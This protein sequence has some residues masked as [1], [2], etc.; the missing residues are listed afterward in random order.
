MGASE[1]M[2]VI[3]QPGHFRTL[4]TGGTENRRRVDAVLVR[5]G[6]TYPVT[7]GL[8]LLLLFEQAR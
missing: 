1:Q 7:G 6:A 2:N 4:R 8:W 5:P 3:L